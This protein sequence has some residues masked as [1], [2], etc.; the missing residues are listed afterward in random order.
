MVDRPKPPPDSPEVMARIE[1]GLD[2]V[3]MIARQLRRQLGPFVRVDDLVS[4][5]REGL[6]TA[7]RSFNHERGVPFRRWA[8]YRVR[9]AM[10]DAMRADSNVPRRVYRTIRAIEAAD[11]IHEATQEENAASPLGSAEEAAAKIGTQLGNAAMAMAIAFLSMRPGDAVDRARDPKENPEEAVGQAE[12]LSQIR[13]AIATLP[14]AERSL[15]ERHYFDGISFGQAASEL[16]L[17]KSWASRLHAR[18][19]EA[20]QR[21]VRERVPDRA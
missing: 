6:L 10:L 12:L 15:L 4:Q 20:V 21:V 5:G 1:E 7:A 14:D 9:G 19:I 8:S 18:A 13:A 2:L 3:D 16:G 17:S 11:H